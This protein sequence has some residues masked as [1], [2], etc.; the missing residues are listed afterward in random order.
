MLNGL[1]AAPRHVIRR[2]TWH[3][4]QEQV[5]VVGSHDHMHVSQNGR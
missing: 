2:S 3:F 5:A 4:P 1:R